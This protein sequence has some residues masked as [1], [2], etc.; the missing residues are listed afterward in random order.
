VGGF[1]PLLAGNGE[2]TVR[3]HSLRA[4]V[5]TATRDPGAGQYQ[6]G[7]FDPLLA[8]NGEP[9]VR[10]HSLRARV[11]TATRDPGAGQYQ[12]AKHL[13]FSKITITN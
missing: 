10:Y 12:A 1:D 13:F 9:T 6:V 11:L 7:G 3:Y 8:G 5:L 2:P 4:R